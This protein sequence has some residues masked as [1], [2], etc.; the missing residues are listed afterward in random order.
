MLRTK[1]MP[2]NTCTLSEQHPDVP[3]PAHVI[4]AADV[5]IGLWKCSAALR[6][7]GHHPH[8]CNGP[9]TTDCDNAPA[10]THGITVDPTTDVSLLFCCNVAHLKAATELVMQ[11]H[12][13]PPSVL[14]L[15]RLCLDR[16]ATATAATT[17]LL[18]ETRQ[19]SL[20]AMVWQHVR[21]RGPHTGMWNMVHRV[22]FFVN[23]FRDTAGDAFTRIQQ[24]EC[25][26]HSLAECPRLAVELPDGFPVTPSCLCYEGHLWL[27][28][29]K[30]EAIRGDDLDRR[31]MMSGLV[32]AASAGHL[33]TM[34]Y[35]C[36]LPHVLGTGIDPD[37]VIGAATNGHIRVVEYL[38]NLRVNVAAHDNKAFIQ[39]AGN[40]HLAILK[41]L[42]GLPRKQGVDPAAQLSLAV[43]AAA[44]HGRVHV[45]EWL[46]GLPRDRG[47][48]P[49]A[50]N[51]DAVRLACMHGRLGAVK[52][53]CDLPCDRGVYVTQE[54]L[55]CAQGSGKVDLNKYLATL[56]HFG[57][58]SCL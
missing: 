58:E 43:S 12:L 55:A 30:L 14:A 25:A 31:D 3:A 36:S 32:M 29:H 17:L 11:G 4:R 8:N 37:A 57:N 16:V 15:S 50:R 53:L 39:A 41:F 19:F 44:A 33:F 56:L 13:H 10:E 6:E 26:T 21:C 54:A 27:L 47:V 46:C 52:F 40:G 48:D 22:P 51:N 1:A 28:R 5:P 18:D 7:L 49:A 23:W 35:L 38:C 2:N 9:H 34:K 20:R 24:M 42:Y 45:L